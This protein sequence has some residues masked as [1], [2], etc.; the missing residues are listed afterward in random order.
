MYCGWQCFVPHAAKGVLD[1]DLADNLVAVSL[2]LLEE[3]ALGWDELGE[4]LL[5]VLLR[6]GG[7]A[8]VGLENDWADGGRL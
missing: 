3:L 7:I 5:K 1:L 6:T 4:G 2:D 8:A